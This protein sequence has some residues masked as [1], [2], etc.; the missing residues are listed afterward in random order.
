MNRNFEYITFDINGIIYACHTKVA[1]LVAYLRISDATIAQSVEHR[2]C[3]PVVVGSSPTCGFFAPMVKRRSSLTSNEM[4][5]V[6]ILVG[7]LISDL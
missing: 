7:V 2:F 3:K 1:R 4:F 5:Q 6:R